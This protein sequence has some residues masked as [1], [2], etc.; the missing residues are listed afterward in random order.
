M[1]AIVMG[2]V[3]LPVYILE[4]VMDTVCDLARHAWNMGRNAHRER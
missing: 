1:A 2:A 3:M 4:S